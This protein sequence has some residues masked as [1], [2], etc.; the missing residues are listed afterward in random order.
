[1]LWTLIAI[2]LYGAIY[3]TV[4]KNAVED[5]SKELEERRKRKE[6]K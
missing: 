3:L 4:I 1:M 6:K 2:I 5:H